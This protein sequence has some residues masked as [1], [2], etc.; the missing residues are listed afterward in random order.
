MISA[1]I[2]FWFNVIVPFSGFALCS[3]F[4]CGLF[5]SKDLKYA[6]RIHTRETFSWK[7]ELWFG[8][9]V[10]V[11]RVLIGIVSMFEFWA[12]HLGTLREFLVGLNDLSVEAPQQAAATTRSSM[13]STSMLNQAFR[14]VSTATRVSSRVQGNVVREVASEMLNMV[15]QNARGTTT[16]TTTSIARP[17][18]SSSST[19]TTPPIFEA[20]LSSIGTAAA[21]HA[22]PAAPAA[23]PSPPSVPDVA[24]WD[25]N[26]DDDEDQGEEEDHVVPDSPSGFLDKVLGE[27]MRA[28]EQ[29]ETK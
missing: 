12:R 23:L 1:A 3:L 15:T 20:L 5:L 27:R 13:A 16:S 6:A 4:L 7:R 9:A 21:A 22:A 19:S 29:Q 25:Q 14:L 8:I 26:D 11:D 18:P 28:K 17:T 10:A 2:S 24:P